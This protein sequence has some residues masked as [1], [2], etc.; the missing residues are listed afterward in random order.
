MKKYVIIGNPVAN[1]QSPEIYNFLFDYFGIDSHYTRLLL[2][3]V[4]HFRPIFDLISLSG[5]NITMPHKQSAYSIADEHDFSS[6]ITESANTLIN[7]ESIKSF[8]TDFLAFQKLINT[9]GLLSQ[10]GTALVLGSGNTANTVIRVLRKYNFDVSVINRTKINSDILKTEFPD[11]NIVEPNELQSKYDLLVNAVPDISFLIDSLKAISFGSVIDF[12]YIKDQLQC[13]RANCNG[14]IDGFQIL[15]SQAFFAFDIYTGNRFELVAKYY[16]TLMPILH[17]KLSSPKVKKSNIVLIGFSG[18]GKTT[19]G[20]AI[21]EKLGKKFVDTDEL[22][23]QIEG[24][25][26]NEIFETH[27]ESY[28]RQLE[29]NIAG[30]ISHYTDSVISTGGGFAEN[31]SNIN[32]IRNN[33]FVVWLFTDINDTLSRLD[34]QQKPKLANRSNDEIVHLFE[35]RKPNYFKNADM[36]FYNKGNFDTAIEVLSDELSNAKI[37]A[38]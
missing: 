23:Q 24:K 2:N 8:N 13:L 19:I 4:R 37:L 33:S 27:G 5:C 22:I 35:T 14:F 16:D 30:E 25:S 31:P 38:L 6:A 29:S 12:N 1:S 36:I 7:H 17:N 21:A 10:S 11:V 15:I 20:K 32:S 18:S 28:F 3:D 26:I 34:T 9:N